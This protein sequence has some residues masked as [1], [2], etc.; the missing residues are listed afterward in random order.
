MMLRARQ[1][2]FT[3]I[4][5]MVVL[6]IIGIVISTIVISIKTDDI[7]EH[8]KIEMNRLQALVRLAREEAILQ[9]QVMALAVGE[10]SYRF[11]VKDIEKDTWS[12]MQDDQV[13]RERN[14][15]PG[16]HFVLVIDDVKNEKR[17][18][19]KLELSEDRKQ[20]EQQQD[21]DYKR[22]QIDPSGEIFPFE[23]IMSNEDETIEYKLVM[24]EDGKLSVIS[25]EEF[26]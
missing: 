20:P 18:K 8:M 25:P 13:F 9:G 19:F 21:D 15:V 24:G 6:I 7:G 16:T 1:A 10:K 14:L 3:L 11:D 12:A 17:D 4:E 2:G 5:M 23:L 26:I 22:V